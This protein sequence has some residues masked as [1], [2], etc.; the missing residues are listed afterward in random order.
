MK[1]CYKTYDMEV[2]YKTENKIDYNFI[3]FKEI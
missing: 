2:C 1:V 3:V